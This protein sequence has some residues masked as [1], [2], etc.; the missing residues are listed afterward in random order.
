[1]SFDSASKPHRLEDI[2]RSNLTVPSFVQ[3]EGMEK[4]RRRPRWIRS[5]GKL[6][7]KSTG[8]L[9]GFRRIGKI[10]RRSRIGVLEE[11][12]QEHKE[13]T[14]DNFDLIHNEHAL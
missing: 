10:R 11:N 1:M 3:D 8:I 7:R 2:V 4:S 13:Q 5:I 12:K 14:D 9:K 6:G